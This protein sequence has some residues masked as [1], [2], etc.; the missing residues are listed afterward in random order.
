MMRG[1]DRIRDLLSRPDRGVGATSGITGVLAGMFRQMLLDLNINGMK[2][3]HLM[4]EYVQV[5]SE[6]HNKNNRRD[7]TSIRSNLN[8]EFIR[9]RMTWK[10]FCRG[11]MLLK[12]RRFGIVIIAEHENGRKTAH[13]TIVDMSTA[14]ST[15][16]DDIESFKEVVEDVKLGNIGK[17]K[18]KEG[19][20]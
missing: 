1:K 18:Q 12:I 17:Y 15:P 13:S 19:G 20:V 5:E 16:Q 10:V 3:S 11:M 9:C 14:D 2:W 4:D 7:R 6:V 8:K